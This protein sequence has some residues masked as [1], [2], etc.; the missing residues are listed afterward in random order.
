ML[1]PTVVKLWS[2]ILMIERAQVFSVLL[3]WLWGYWHQASNVMCGAHV[4]LNEQGFWHECPDFPRYLNIWG[5]QADSLQLLSKCNQTLEIQKHDPKS[6]PPTSVKSFLLILTFLSHSWENSAD[7]FT[8]TFQKHFWSHYFTTLE[9]AWDQGVY[10]ARGD[11]AVRSG[12]RLQTCLPQG[13]WA[14]SSA[15]ACEHLGSVGMM[16]RNICLRCQ[17]LMYAHVASSS[18]QPGTHSAAPLAIV[19]QPAAKHP[20][21]AFLHLWSMSPCRPLL[22]VGVISS[23][24]NRWQKIGL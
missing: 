12:C 14:E 10:P 21:P 22:L 20:S 2:T 4:S 16:Q 6:E 11:S 24:G 13:L 23:L 17:S 19:S 15:C 9:G 1:F 7:F 5:S 3:V 8:S 18:Q